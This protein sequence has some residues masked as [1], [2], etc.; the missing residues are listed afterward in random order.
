MAKKTDKNLYRAKKKREGFSSKSYTLHKDVTA[1]IDEIDKETKMGKSEI[2]AEA[3]KAYYQSDY[4]KAA[5][6]KA[7]TVP[8][9]EFERYKIMLDLLIKD[10]LIEVHEF[11][12]ELK[13]ATVSKLKEYGKSFDDMMQKTFFDEYKEVNPDDF[14]SFRAMK[15]LLHLNQSEFED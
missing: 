12:Q 4:K 2:V 5:V 13:T 1:M 7:S 3:I 14:K 11:N 15:L 6:D 8:N 9:E 10:Y